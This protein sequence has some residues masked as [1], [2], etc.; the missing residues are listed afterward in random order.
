MSY[1]LSSRFPYRHMRYLSALLLTGIFIT[2]VQGICSEPPWKNQLDDLNRQLHHTVQL[3]ERLSHATDISPVLNVLELA[4]AVTD[5][6]YV[7]LE[8]F[9][10]LKN[11]NPAQYVFDMAIQLKTA[12]GQVIDSLNRIIRTSMEPEDVNIAKQS[13][14]SAESLKDRIATLMKNSL[15]FGAVPG[16]AEAYDA[17]SRST[18]DLPL[19]EDPPIQDS[20]PAS[21]I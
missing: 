20:E 5:R 3:T 21:P 10:N 18:L 16:P 2:T 7:S 6:L 13:V 19:A 9:R 17:P 15:E 8:Q 4:H 12:L 1:L 11:E 14:A